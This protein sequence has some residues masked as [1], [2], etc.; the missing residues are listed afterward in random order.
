MIA[1]AVYAPLSFADCNT[2][3]TYISPT[4][5][6]LQGAATAAKKGG[7][8]S[9]T[10][11]ETS[12]LFSCKNMTT[13]QFWTLFD[14]W[15][16]PV[17]TVIFEGETYGL[18]PTN[19]A[20]VFMIVSLA[21]PSGRFNPVRYIRTELYG[22]VAGSDGNM[23]GAIG[24]R[25]R[26]FSRSSTMA[27]GI[28]TFPR[29]QLSQ[30]INMQIYNVVCRRECSA[31]LGNININAFSFNVNGIS[32][33]LVAPGQVKLRSVNLA[34]LSSAGATVEGASL[35]MGVSCNKAYS[36]YNIR[37]SMIDV[38]DLSNT[39]S[40]LQISKSPEQASGISL[41]VLD[42]GD[43]IKFGVTYD[44]GKGLIGNMPAAGGVLN[45]TLSVRYVRTEG[46]LTPGKV[47]AG[48]TVTLSYE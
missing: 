47:N 18:F 33:K 10:W 16:N 29:V 41:Q 19:V 21:G 39:S 5:N 4:I 7:M 17:D 25:V 43:P 3:T 34:L 42:N 48:V 27:P 31:P 6:Q 2:D 38:N 30:R 13:G 20:D 12:K 23:K 9:S 14:L 35:Q 36:A 45:K 44:P 22:Y 46:I 11:H 8:L 24:V 15:Y 26:Y 28:R 32:C 40:S 37:Y 1:L